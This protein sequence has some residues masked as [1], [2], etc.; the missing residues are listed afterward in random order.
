MV[1]VF[2][3]TDPKSADDIMPL[4][5]EFYRQTRQSATLELDEDAVRTLVGSLVESEAGAVFVA[6]DKDGEVIGTT[7][8]MLFPLWMCPAHTTGQEMFWYVREDRRRSK[9]GKLLFN[10]LEKWAKEHADSFNMVALS[11]MHEK[12]IGNMYESKGYVP[13]ERTYTK[14][15]K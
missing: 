11:H 14:E 4:L 7:A 10:A 12:R 3:L 6:V 15:F 5:R 2:E 8:G 13:L 1:Q 9:A